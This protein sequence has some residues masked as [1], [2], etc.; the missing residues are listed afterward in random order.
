MQCGVIFSKHDLAFWGCWIW[1]FN[2][3]MI[4]A[5]EKENLSYEFAFV[6]TY[7]QIQPSTLDY[8]HLCSF[9][10]ASFSFGT[11]VYYWTLGPV[12]GN[13]TLSLRHLAGV[14][15]WE[16]EPSP[17]HSLW[18]A[19]VQ[20]ICSSEEVCRH[21]VFFC[22][23]SS[24]ESEPETGNLQMYVWCYHCRNRFTVHTQALT[25]TSQGQQSLIPRR[26]VILRS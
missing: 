4:N 24:C 16:K 5:E 21:A 3:D 7:T 17:P 25:D 2:G 11:Q 19:N 18:H 10:Q 14:Q 8:Q 12:G 22:W 26:T 6:D 9:A 20:I 15:S 23:Q 13:E 1:R